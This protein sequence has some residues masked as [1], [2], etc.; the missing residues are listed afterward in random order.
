LGYIAAFGFSWV[1]LRI[2]SQTTPI[3]GE[4]A[5]SMKYVLTL[6]FACGLGCGVPKQISLPTVYR[7]HQQ[8]LVAGNV[9]LSPEANPSH[10]VRDFRCDKR[11]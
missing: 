3:G 4:L 10:A 7:S 11:R 5:S 6:L 1:G 2:Q 9:W 8:C